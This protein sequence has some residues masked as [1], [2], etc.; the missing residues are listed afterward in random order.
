MFSSKTQNV[1]I[2]LF[3]ILICFIWMEILLSLSRNSWED[4]PKDTILVSHRTD[5]GH[6]MMRILSA[7]PGPAAE[8]TPTASTGT[9][10]KG[11]SKVEVES[12]L[13]STIYWTLWNIT[14]ANKDEHNGQEKAF[15]I[16]ALQAVCLSLHLLL[17][18]V[19]PTDLQNGNNIRGRCGSVRSLGLKL[20]FGLT[21]AF[22]F[23]STNST[24]SSSAVGAFR[25][26]GSWFWRGYGRSC[27]KCWSSFSFSSLFGM[28]MR[29]TGASSEVL[30]K[31]SVEVELRHLEGLL[32]HEFLAFVYILE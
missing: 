5:T 27:Q 13:S 17:L 1:R 19:F 8:V 3:Y 10:V 9:T 28:G 11:Q 21:L 24:S 14:P 6:A 12:D 30:V 26:N 15:D 4:V 25:F 32:I 7:I 31:T 18:L 29:E 16:L 2:W 20:L 22:S 23:K